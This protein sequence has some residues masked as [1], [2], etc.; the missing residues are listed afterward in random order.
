MSCKLYN[1]N[2]HFFVA[3]T[4]ACSFVSY[5]HCFQSF[6]YQPIEIVFASSRFYFVFGGLHMPQYPCKILPRSGTLGVIN[7]VSGSPKQ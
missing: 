1:N 2:E 3:F 6:I 4:H 7:Q 5:R